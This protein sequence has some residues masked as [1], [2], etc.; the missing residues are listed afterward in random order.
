MTEGHGPGR[1]TGFFRA[2]RLSFTRRLGALAWTLFHLQLGK[3]LTEVLALISRPACLSF[4][5]GICQSSMV[6]SSS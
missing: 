4:C 6:E 1:M 5:N 2:V 3:E